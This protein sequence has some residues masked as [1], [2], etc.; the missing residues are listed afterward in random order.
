[1]ADKIFKAYSPRLI[2]ALIV[3]GCEPLR[4]DVDEVWFRR[5][6]DLGRVIDDFM[7]RIKNA[8]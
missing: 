2:A 4:H 8:P 6:P 1:M 3:A 7:A 5:T